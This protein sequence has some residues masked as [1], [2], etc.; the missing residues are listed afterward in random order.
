MNI[1]N[2]L[3]LFTALSDCWRCNRSM[4]DNCQNALSTNTRQVATSKYSNKYGD[5]ISQER[6]PVS[7]LDG[8]IAPRTSSLIRNPNLYLERATLHLNLHPSRSYWLTY[9]NHTA[10]R[11]KSGVYAEVVCRQ[12]GERSTSQRRS[13]VDTST[14][15]VC[16][17]IPQYVHSLVDVRV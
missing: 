4:S 3:T 5:S 6:E 1:R 11:S 15:A 17:L 13:H 2:I 9:R 10:R 8:Y 16:P 12:C 14:T 7:T